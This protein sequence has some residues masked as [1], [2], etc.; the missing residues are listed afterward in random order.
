MT[1]A[2]ASSPL[3]PIL[4]RALLLLQW[5]VDRAQLFQPP[6]HAFPH[7]HQAGS[8]GTRSP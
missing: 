1:T 3:D 4:K 5:G 8:G 7:L 2:E 6:V